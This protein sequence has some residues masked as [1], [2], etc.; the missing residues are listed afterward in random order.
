M[1]S[2]LR[3]SMGL[4]VDAELAVLSACDSGRGRETVGGDV[5]GLARGLIASGVRR[6]VVSLW[7]VDDAAACVTMA[8]FHD[9]LAGGIAP[10]LQATQKAVRAMSG[11]D[12]AAHYVDLGGDWGDVRRTR[13]RGA[14]QGATAPATSLPLDPELIDDLTDDEPLET[15]T[16]ATPRIWAPFVVI[17]T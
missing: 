2:L 10:A 9:R 15:L 17:G 6:S 16:G 8:L 5:V 11:S 7:P 14:V 3:T 13:R 12:I 1:N 4:R